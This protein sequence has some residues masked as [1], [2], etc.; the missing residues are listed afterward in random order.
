MSKRPQCRNSARFL[1]PNRGFAQKD[2]L[3]G[4]CVFYPVMSVITIIDVLMSKLFDG[5]EGSEGDRVWDRLPCR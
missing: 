1:I 4:P 3:L 2:G 5:L